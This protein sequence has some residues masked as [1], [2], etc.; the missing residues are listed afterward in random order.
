MTIMS[1]EKYTFQS[2][3]PR[4]RRQLKGGSCF[5]WQNF[6]PRLREGGD[7]NVPAKKPERV[8]ISIHA[9]AKEA[10][11]SFN[12]ISTEVLISIHASAKE[13]TTDTGWKRWVF[14]HFN[15]RL[16]EGGDAPFLIQTAGSYLISI[17]ASA[18]EATN[19]I[20]CISSL[21]VKFQSTPPR[22]RRRTD[23]WW[24]QKNYFISIHASA[25]EATE[26]PDAKTAIWIFQSTPPRRRRHR[27]HI[28]NQ[29]RY[30]FNPRLREGGDPRE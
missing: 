28:C 12:C 19:C 23:W 11:F 1:R 17:H 29:Y 14:Y 26:V 10:T 16:R 3:P 18:K 20:E 9:S 6:N 27:R 4:R 5:I 30:D 8:I 22:R 25:K 21:L 7:A 24:V 2:T 15:P 13:A